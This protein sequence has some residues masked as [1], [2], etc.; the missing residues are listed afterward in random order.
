MSVYVYRRVLIVVG[1]L[2][3]MVLLYGAHAALKTLIYLC[4]TIIYS[5]REAGNFV[6]PTSDFGIWS[7]NFI[8][9]MYTKRYGNIPSIYLLNCFIHRNYE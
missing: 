6:M 3:I 7:E 8:L 9:S 5:V 1:V 2:M 4:C